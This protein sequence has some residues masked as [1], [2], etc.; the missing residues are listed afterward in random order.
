[1]TAFI[2]SSVLLEIAIVQ[3]SHLDRDSPT[4]TLMGRA[5]AAL[6]K[7]DATRPRVFVRLHEVNCHETICQEWRGT[8]TQSNVAYGRI[9]V[10]SE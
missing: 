1:M 7:I 2:L 4:S 10:A 8:E 6:K 9:N 3:L 5:G